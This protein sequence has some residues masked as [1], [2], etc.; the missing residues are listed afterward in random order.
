MFGDQLQGKVPINKSPADSPSVTPK[1]SPA[2]RRESAMSGLSNFNIN[3]A[4]VGQTKLRLH[5]VHKINEE[6]EPQSPNVRKES[7]RNL[8]LMSLG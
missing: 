8:K 3:S 5:T 6:L 1:A 4:D 2:R 7:S